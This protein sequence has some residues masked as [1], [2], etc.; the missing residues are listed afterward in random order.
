[1][2]KANAYLNANC[3]VSNIR[4]TLSYDELNRLIS[5]RRNYTINDSL[6]AIEKALE[7]LITSIK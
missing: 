6:K 3:A 2:K 7:I 5:E 1:M 4:R